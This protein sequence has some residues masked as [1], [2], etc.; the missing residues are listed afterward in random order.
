MFSF[1]VIAFGFLH[2]VCAPLIDIGFGLARR[3]ARHWCKVS[4]AFSGF[5]AAGRI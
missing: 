3:S 2:S 5:V 1:R 4:F